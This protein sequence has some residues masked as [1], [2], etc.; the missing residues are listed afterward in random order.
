MLPCHWLIHSWLGWFLWEAGLA[1]TSSSTAPW[2]PQVPLLAS[3][4]SWSRQLPNQSQEKKEKETHWPPGYFLSSLSRKE[5]LRS[6]ERRGEGFP[7]L[8]WT[9]LRNGKS[10]EW[11]SAPYPRCLLSEPTTLFPP[12]HH[13]LLPFL[14]LLVSCDVHSSHLFFHLLNMALSACYRGKKTLQMRYPYDQAT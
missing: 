12:C 1:N 6:A 14:A 7:P 5:H 3:L 13:P 2:T 4:W 10:R 9:P 8:S 11:L